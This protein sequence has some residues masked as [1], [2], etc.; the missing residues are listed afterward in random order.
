M[1]SS[2]VIALFPVVALAAVNGKC[3]GTATG[4]WLSDGICEPTAT[5]DYYHGTYITG[6][7]PNDVDD[8]KCCLVGLDTSIDGKVISC[9]TVL[10]IITLPRYCITSST[11]SLWS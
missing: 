2:Y 4:F 10:L 3:S 1:Y 11:T 7:C 6:G 5:C 9:S 8:V